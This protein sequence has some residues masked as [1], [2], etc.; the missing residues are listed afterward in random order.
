MAT[1]T[2]NYKLTKP[3][4]TD[5]YDVEVQNENMDIIDNQLKKNQEEINNKT[6]ENMGAFGYIGALKEGT[7]L[8]S[9][10]TTGSYTFTGTIAPTIKNTPITGTGCH[11]HVFKASDVNASSESTRQTIQLLTTTSI[12]Y[13]QLY[14]RKHASGTWT[15]W[16]ELANAVEFLKLTGGTL[17]GNLIISKNSLPQ[18]HLYNPTISRSLRMELTDDGW[19]Q[20]WAQ[21]YGSTATSACMVLKT[22]N[23]ATEELLQVKTRKDGTLKA[24]NVFGGHNKTSGTYIGNGSTTSRKI[25]TSGIG[26]AVLITGEGT[27]AILT[28][29]GAITWKSDGTNLTAIGSN[30]VHFRDG[31]I[32]LATTNAV[33][34]QNAAVYTYQVI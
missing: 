31:V 20:L 2:T 9:L 4:S 24:Y 3:A 17:L 22:E 18:V 29:Y 21:V 14:W 5:F 8:N 28:T 16:F 1:Q 23:D 11:I 25:D 6:I 33:F 30:Q 12:N 10:L 19:M 26:K 32:T 27:A 34:N 13:T 15:E 7:D